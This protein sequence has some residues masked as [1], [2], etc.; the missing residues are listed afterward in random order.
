MSIPWFQFTTVHLGPIPLQVWGFFVAL[1]MVLS[2][3]IVWRW[4]G[5][6]GYEKERVLDTAVWC[7]VGGIIGARLAHVF[8]YAPTYY[9]A[10]PIEIVK[11]W[12]GGM[13]SFGGFAGAVAVFCLVYKKYAL[14]NWQRLADLL[15]FAALYGWIVGRVGCV[16]IHDH[17]G[18]V[19]PQCLL[20]IRTP[21]GTVRLDMALLE[22]I[23]LLPLAIVFYLWR[24]KTLP[25][26]YRFAVLM[27][28]YGML[29]M[30]LDFFRARDI[31]GADV[32]YFG[33]TPAQYFAMIFVF[34]SGYWWKR[35]VRS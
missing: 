20:G 30:I 33:L 3:I 25:D 7:I 2:L 27:V 16:M 32:R 6:Y 28:Y 29:R 12:H 10:H 4:S 1:G 14:A 24:K 18:V 17:L 9:F 23:G 5:Y 21:D 26:G 19:C 35:A 8:L 22:I 31:L 13:S 11:V 15:G 34:M